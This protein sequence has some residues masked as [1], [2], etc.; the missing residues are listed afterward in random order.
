[1]PI[2]TEEDTLVNFKEIVYDVEP[3]RNTCVGGEGIKYGRGYAHPSC[4]PY[5][6]LARVL[7]I[8]AASMIND[9][10]TVRQEKS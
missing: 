7:M 8:N 3:L 1:M 5:R 2:H 10:T 9:S 4:D 6:M